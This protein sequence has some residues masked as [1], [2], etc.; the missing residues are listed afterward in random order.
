MIG[1]ENLGV[2]G[3]GG[4]PGVSVAPS[5]HSAL[6]WAPSGAAF[7]GTGA[8]QVEGICRD[9]RGRPSG[10]LKVDTPRLASLVK[11]QALPSQIGGAGRSLRNHLV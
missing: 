8:L 10:K 6:C 3:L 1:S 5:G 7:W 11:W 9:L 2:Q 4:C